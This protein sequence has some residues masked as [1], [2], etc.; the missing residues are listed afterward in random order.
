[1]TQNLPEALQQKLDTRREALRRKYQNQMRW[2]KRWAEIVL[3]F[4]GLYVGLP[5]LAPALLKA[6][7]EQPA[8]LIYTLYSPLCHQMAFRSIFLFGEQIF[9]PRE[10]ANDANFQTFDER[11]AQSE[12][13]VALY[14]EHKR[15]QLRRQFGQDVA[16]NYQ[17]R[18]AEELAEWDNALVFAARRFK[19]DPQMGY[20]VTLCARDIAIYGG[21]VLGGVFFLFTRRRLRPVPFALYL[22]LGIVPI[23]LDGFSQLLSYPPFEFWPPRE[24]LPEFRVITG[25]LFGLMNAW[26]AFPYV[27]QAVRQS[28]QKT[29]AELNRL[30]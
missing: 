16:D 7:I 29:Q 25:L 24:A 3:F 19:G 30:G 15:A 20:K 17:F 8:N 4:L 10:A 23:G 27:E 11:A 26:L 12:E 1:V 28:Q 14:T 5:F 22:L 6:G 13:F 9:Y 2:Q 18:G 21:M